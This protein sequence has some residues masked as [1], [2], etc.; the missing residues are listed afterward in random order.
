MSTLKNLAL[1]TYFTLL[2]MFPTVTISV[3]LFAVIF[4]AIANKKRVTE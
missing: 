1:A 3:S 2:V 4:A